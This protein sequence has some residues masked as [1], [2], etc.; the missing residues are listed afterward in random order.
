VRHSIFLVAASVIL[1]ADSS[2]LRAQVPDR[3]NDLVQQARDL[4]KNAQDSAVANSG[5]FRNPFAR[6]NTIGANGPQ[7]GMQNAVPAA[8]PGVD[9]SESAIEINVGG[10][11]IL[12]PRTG[13]DAVGPGMALITGNSGA[14]PSTDGI[15]VTIDGKLPG[16]GTPVRGMAVDPSG[17][18]TIHRNGSTISTAAYR[19]FAAGSDAF[20][21]ADYSAAVEHL[22]KSVAANPNDP[23]PHSL[24]SLALFA[25]GKYDAAAEYAYS[26]AANSPVWDWEQLRFLYAAPEHY[27]VQYEQLQLAARLASATPGTHFL[28]AWHHLMLGHRES[29]QAELDRVLQHLP[30]DPVAMRLM[31]LARQPVVPPPQPMK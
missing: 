9:I 29:A 10:Q 22:E 11:R 27:T 24:Y 18:V 2:P 8:R 19:E 13:P 7:V 17:D 1:A 21:K 3:V 16:A 12:V 5:T 4:A 6:G 20:R 26:A 23:M 25:N 30:N 15:G 31:N 14:N 28:L